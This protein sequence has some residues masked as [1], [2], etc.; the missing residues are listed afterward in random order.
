MAVDAKSRSLI[1]EDN[2]ATMLSNRFTMRS[3]NLSF[4][5]LFALLIAGGCGPTI[6][7]VKGTATLDGKPLKGAYISFNNQTTGMSRECPIKEDGTYEVKILQGKGLPPGKYLVAVHPHHTH[8]PPNPGP[9]GVVHS[10]NIIDKI[11][12]KYRNHETS[13]LVLDLPAEGLVF[14]VTLLSKD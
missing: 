13:N 9:D 12:N 8:I 6:A 10:N 4:C 5:L 3:F 2:Q 14:D 1:P 11:P 7:S